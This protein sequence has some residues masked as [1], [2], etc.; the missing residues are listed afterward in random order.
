M[1]LGLSHKA[2]AVAGVTIGALVAIIGIQELRIHGLKDDVAGAQAILQVCHDANKQCK[3]DVEEANQTAQACIDK[4]DQDRQAARDA[5][6]RVI[7]EREERER[8]LE[9]DIEIMRE[10]LADAGPGCL[11]SLPDAVDRR[12]RAGTPY[13]N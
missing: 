13:E 3:T 7:R 1:I 4:S 10:Q 11:Y 5:V 6:R 12:L 2:L 8:E 9:S